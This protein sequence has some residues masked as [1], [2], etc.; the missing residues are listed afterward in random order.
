M[1]PFKSKAGFFAGRFKMASTTGD[2]GE[3]CFG[4]LGVWLA[5]ASIGT[6]GAEAS[7]T[8]SGAGG[9]DAGLTEADATGGV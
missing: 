6:A 4:A 7:P 2:G 5:R 8:D 3:G 1:L 9:Y